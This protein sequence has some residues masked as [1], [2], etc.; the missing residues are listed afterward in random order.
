ME[1]VH[2]DNVLRVGFHQ[3]SVEL[4][5]VHFVRGSLHHD[6]KAFLEDRDGGDRHDDR[7]DIGA[8]GVSVPEVGPDVDDDGRDNN[9]DGHNEIAENVESGS[10]DVHVPAT[11]LSVVVSV[12][13]PVG[14]TVVVSVAMTMVV[15]FTFFVVVGV[16]AFTKMEVGVSGMKNLDLNKVEDQAHDGDDE[17][18][19]ALDHRFHKEAASGF[20]EEPDGHNPDGGDRNERSNQLG[21]V[22]SER[23]VFICFECTQLHTSNC[24]TETEKI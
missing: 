10:V 24:D 17:H 21:S 1:I 3:G 20:F 19:L 14:V 5:D 16:E 22:S 18:E 15:T 13:V 23:K 9:A 8:D 12:G 6:A 2:L 4:F 7:E 11:F